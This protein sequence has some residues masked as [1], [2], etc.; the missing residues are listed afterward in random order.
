MLLGILD[1]GQLFGGEV[2]FGWE[3]QHKNSAVSSSQING[4]A[5][6]ERKEPRLKGFLVYLLLA[7]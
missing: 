2:I 4:K 1:L 5:S 6:S 7:K 3:R